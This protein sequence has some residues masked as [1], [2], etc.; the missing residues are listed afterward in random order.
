M[1]R[2]FVNK[3]LQSSGYNEVHTYSC[4]EITLIA[5]RYFLGEFASPVEALKKAEQ[6]L[7]KYRLCLYCSQPVAPPAIN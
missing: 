1:E 3:D 6:S 5:N 4:P 2:Y 7:Q